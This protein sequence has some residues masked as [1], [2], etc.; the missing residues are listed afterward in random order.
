TLARYQTLARGGQ[1]GGLE[2]VVAPTAS[3]AFEGADQQVERAVRL[4]F[5]KH[6]ASLT[7]GPQI[8]RRAAGW[9]E[10]PELARPVLDRFVAKRL[11]AVGGKG[12]GR[13][14]VVTHEALFRQWDRLRTW[15]EQSKDV[16]RWR[17]D[18]DR[19]RQNPK[20]RGLTAAQLAVARRWPE[21]RTEE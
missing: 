18:V 13:V 1:A 6:L 19:D 9:G 4:A 15:F 16:L 2:A 12:A 21:Q 8:V 14:V 17:R 5:I 7:E 11:L 10:L 20:W 3:D